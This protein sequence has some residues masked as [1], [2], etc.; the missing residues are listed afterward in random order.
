MK[1]VNKLV[2]DNAKNLAIRLS[3]AEIRKRV[4]VLSAAAMSV[5]DLLD[6]GELKLKHKNSLFKI[7]SLDDALEI[8]DLYSDDIRV[9]V[10]VIFDKNTFYIPK[11]HEKF[12]A[13][14][15]IYLVVRMTED[16]ENIEPVGFIESSELPEAKSNTEYLAYDINILKP[17]SLLKNAIN[18]IEKTQQ[19]FSKEA[20]AKIEELTMAF[21]DGEIS[22]SEKVFFIQHVMKCPFCREKLSEM[23][24]FD[25]VVRQ[26]NKYPDLLNDQTL[27]ILTGALARAY[28]LPEAQPV[29]LPDDEE[30]QDLIIGKP[31]VDEEI[32][33][34]SE[35]SD[36]SL[37]DT[38]TTIEMDLTEND[39]EKPFLLEYPEENADA[40]LSQ[41][42]LLELGS[43]EA[44]NAEEIAGMETP[45]SI[46]STL[47][48][49]PDIT[50]NQDT[51]ISTENEI[52]T[53]DTSALEISK[54]NLEDNTEG[55]NID[56]ANTGNDSED[57]LLDF[58]DDEDNDIDNIDNIDK[59]QATTQEDLG[60]TAES[61]QQ[62]H[63]NI[64]G[65][66]VATEDL[67]LVDAGNST[68]NNLEDGTLELQELTP[69]AEIN[70]PELLEESDDDITLDMID[71]DDN[72]IEETIDTQPLSLDETPQ[73]VMQEEEPANEHLLLLGDEP[74]L[75]M[76]EE[77]PDIEL[78]NSEG[79]ELIVN[80]ESVLPVENTSVQSSDESDIIVKDNEE[81]NT[82][83]EVTE[84]P[85]T[86][87]NV[88]SESVEP[89]PVQ[90]NNEEELNDEM[91]EMLD[92]D[93]RSLLEASDDDDDIVIGD[94]EDTYLAVPSE[95]Q[96]DEEEHKQQHQEVSEVQSIDPEL[97]SLMDDDL[98]A[99]LMDDNIPTV[100]EKEPS[101]PVPKQIAQKLSQQPAENNDI[102]MLYDETTNPSGNK[103][104]QIT[105]EEPPVVKSAVNKTKK[106]AVGLFIFLILLAGG[107]TTYFMKFG[108]S[109]P[110]MPEGDENSTDGG[111]LF[112]FGNKSPDA[113]EE[114][115]VPQDINKSMT[116]VFSEQPS[117]L[118]ITKISWNVN[119]KLAQNDA[120]KN[121][122]QVAGK[123]LQ[124]NLQ[125]DLAN[126]TEFAYNNKI[127]LNF[128]VT[129][130]NEIKNL[131][132][133]DSSGSEQIDNVVLRSIKETL[134]Y[135]NAPN[136]KE[137]KGD[138]NLSL[139]INF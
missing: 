107:T 18:K 39:N 64:T 92:D 16:V 82:Q 133:L 27:D 72:V 114:P 3:S 125:N 77:T 119:D 10:R 100:S 91:Q 51:E 23:N 24:E 33:E 87:L 80:S 89:L 59:I 11:S 122:L 69:D 137:V 118:T 115:A 63:D 96:P 28:S 112:D 126:T 4:F 62:E 81:E 22:D 7:T 67:D 117:A 109:L 105:V 93:L 52:K 6:D 37:D 41:E 31:I 101:V 134:K 123:N 57:F 73:E 40:K 130:N 129:K 56:T 132:V 61:F 1:K 95:A 14:P 106:L 135:I 48:I 42:T 35:H 97:Q 12:Y 83:R 43:V 103:E 110:G 131:Q 2:L 139:I 79:Q 32:T 26:L 121:Y 127:H 38:N 19:I 44:L 15:E 20:H 29:F 84:P 8:A 50:V 85:E 60:A 13:T 86:A 128:Q 53:E 9:D 76:D 94:T 124:M 65:D 68:E 113:E 55:Q 75:L 5:S 90:N 45:E 46:D 116:N 120:F 111:A 25:N 99:M 34:M 88:I 58:A 71:D 54:T 47:D 36:D 138:Y 49:T 30:E 136:I 21:L 70:E 66:T 108:K 78:A 74:E 17:V 98:M 104:S 102:E